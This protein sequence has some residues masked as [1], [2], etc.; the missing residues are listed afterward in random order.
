MAKSANVNLEVYQSTL[1]GA[2]LKQ[3]WS[4]E[5]KLAT[6]KLIPD[7]EYDKVVFK[8]LVRIH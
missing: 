2:T 4:G 6:R 3:H 5:R 1:G 7:N 8:I